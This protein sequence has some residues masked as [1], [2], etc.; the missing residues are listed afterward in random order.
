MHDKGSLAREFCHAI[1]QCEFSGFQDVIDNPVRGLL[2]LLYDISEALN[3]EDETP[4]FFLTNGR[5][6]SILLV[7]KSLVPIPT[8]F[9]LVFLGTEILEVTDPGVFP[10]SH[11]RHH[12]RQPGSPSSRRYRPSRPLLPAVLARARW[13]PAAATSSR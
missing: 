5:S 7:R 9:C 13:P 3:G 8:I 2:R 12:P 1:Q 6:P 10:G 11:A 4:R